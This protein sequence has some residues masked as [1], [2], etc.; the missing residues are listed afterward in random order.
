MGGGRLGKASDNEKSAIRAES[1]PCQ[2]IGGS[3]QVV[4]ANMLL[5]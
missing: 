1:N 5:T 3:C 2:T 4:V